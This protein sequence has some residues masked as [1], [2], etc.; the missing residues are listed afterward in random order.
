[1][2]WLREEVNQRIRS[3]QEN[4]RNKG[5]DAALLVQS[6]DLIYYTGTCQSAH[7]YIPADGKPVFMVRRDIERARATAAVD[8]IV[9]LKSYRELPG[10]IAEHGLPL[11]GVIGLEF[12]VLPVSQYMQYERHFPSVRFTDV[13]PLIRRQRAVK[14]VN[15]IAI[16]AESGRLLDEMLAAVPRVVGVG[17]T[18]VEMSGA[19]E[20]EARRLGHQGLVRFRGMN[21]DFFMGHFLTG[22]SGAEP[23]C[24]EGPVSG[25]GLD[26]T[27]AFGAGR[28]R[29]EAGE[30]IYVDYGMAHRGYITDATR[31]FV[32]GRLSSRLERA[33]AV[34]LEIQAA[35]F[36]GCKPGVSPSALYNLSVQMALQAGLE[37]Y[38]QGWRQPV[39]FIGHGVGLEL[40]E[41]PVIAPGVE[42]PLTEGMVFAIE[43][44]FV[45]PGEGAVGIENT[46]VVTENGA[47]R[48]TNFPDEVCRI[49]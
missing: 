43:P 10:I 9:P 11:P 19:L 15:E 49:A 28:R 18:E 48:L 2:E 5:I 1:M 8:C 22:P 24:F 23:S 35:I 7:L 26:R 44:K 14:S 21:N 13:S 4:L 6:A 12:D 30:P 29:L 32:V 42:D 17:K 16:L 45:F 41:L 31:V 38:F 36:E 37:Q 47:R 33:H 27:F 20:G 3:L 46:V 40:N 34:A 25:P 39:R